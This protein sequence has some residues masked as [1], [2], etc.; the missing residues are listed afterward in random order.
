[1]LRLLEELLGLKLQ[2]LRL[3]QELSGLKL[4]RQAACSLLDLLL[5]SPQLEIQLGRLRRSEHWRQVV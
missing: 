1:L 3:L 4:Q 5:L 2:R